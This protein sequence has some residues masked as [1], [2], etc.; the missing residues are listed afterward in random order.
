[1]NTFT[2][3]SLAVALS[4]ALTCSLSIGAPPALNAVAVA[5]LAQKDLEDRGLQDRIFISRI[6]YKGLVGKPEW[7]VAWNKRFPSATSEGYY[8]IGLR[9]KMDGSYVRRVKK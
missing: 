6:S 8:E 1:M 9:F 5:Q 4:S 2:R 3:I 7:E